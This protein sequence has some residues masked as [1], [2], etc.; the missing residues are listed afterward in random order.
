MIVLFIQ[1]LHNE[2]SNASFD[3]VAL[4][5]IIIAKEISD[6]SKCKTFWKHKETR[7]M[8]TTVLHL[9]V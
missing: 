6:F 7:I 2:W 8:E 5:I 1:S 4:S 9:K 3:C